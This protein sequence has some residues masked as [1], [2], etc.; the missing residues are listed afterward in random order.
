MA[1]TRRV[2]IVCTMGPATASPER[3]LGLVEAGMDVADDWIAERVTNQDVVI[4][5][6]IPLAARCVA[7]GAK[8]LRPNGKALDQNSIG[9]AV[10]ALGLYVGRDRAAG[11]RGSR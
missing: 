2:K 3:M 9:M 4:T 10:A 5:N 6:D 11:M 8:I 7:K 1:V